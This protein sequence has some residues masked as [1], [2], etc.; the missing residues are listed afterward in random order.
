[1]DILEVKRIVERYNS[2]LHSLLG[3]IKNALES[4]PDDPK[5][6]TI[7]QELK[8]AIAETH[9]QLTHTATQSQVTGL[10]DKIADLSEEVIQLAAKVQPLILL[11]EELAEEMKAKAEAEDASQVK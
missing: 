9:R 7:Q 1:M 11:G 3:G 4:R 5:Q 10:D 8:E 6:H 2:L